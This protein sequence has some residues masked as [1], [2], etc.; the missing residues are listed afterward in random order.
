MPQNTLCHSDFVHLHKIGGPHLRSFS[1]AAVAAMVRTACKTVT[2][3]R[4]WI[5]QLEEA[6]YRFL[7][8]EPLVRETL[9]PPCWDCPPIAVN[10]REAAHGFPKDPKWGQGLSEV[11]RKLS[12]SDVQKGPLQRI[13]YNTLIS[14]S[15]LHPLSKGETL[16][17]W[18]GDIFENRPGVHFQKSL[19]KGVLFQT[20]LKKGSIFKLSLKKYPIGAWVPGPG[21]GL[22]GPG[23]GY[24]FELSLK[25]DPLFK[26]V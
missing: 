5:L 12:R 4:S 3:W 22:P 23:L 18:L 7:P 2:N 15:D 21:P 8:L 14:N 16:K 17:K 6:A 20:I 11:I 26:L 13:I 10:L 25:T 1:A 9:S 19:K 24:F